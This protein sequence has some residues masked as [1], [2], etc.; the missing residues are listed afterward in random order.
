MKKAYN[1]NEKDLAAAKDAVNQENKTTKT[2]L[3][4]IN[5]LGAKIESAAKGGGG[6]FAGLTAGA[7]A[8]MV[9]LEP[10]QKLVVDWLLV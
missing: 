10:W 3:D 1:L 4:A 8:V 9:Y 7:G 5:N 6:L 2:Q